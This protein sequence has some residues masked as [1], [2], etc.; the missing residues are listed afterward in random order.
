MWNENSQGFLLGND[1]VFWLL[2]E[3]LCSKRTILNL[4]NYIP[5]GGLSVSVPE[6]I[7]AG[8]DIVLP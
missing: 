3:N 1:N 5:S 6:K 4:E 2:L 7:T 8:S